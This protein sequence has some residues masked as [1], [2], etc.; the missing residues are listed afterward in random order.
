MAYKIIG[1][2]K[3]KSEVI[4]T[5]DDRQEALYLKAEY[6]LAFGAP[7]RIIIKEERPRT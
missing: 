1:T 5:A 4:D 2:Y 7:W 3:G 6:Q